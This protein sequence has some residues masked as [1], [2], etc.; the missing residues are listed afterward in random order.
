MKKLVAAAMKEGA[1]GLSTSLQYVPARFAK[2]DE[3]VELAKVAQQYGGIYATHQRSEANALDESLTEVFEISRRGADSRRDLAPENCLSKEL[4]TH[5]RCPAKDWSGAGAG[6][7]HHCGCLSLHRWQHLA[8][9]LLA[10]MGPRR[11]QRKNARSPARS[12]RAAT[13]EK[14]ISTDSKD[15]ENIYLGSGGPSGVLI[16]SVVNRD[17][18]SLQGKRLVEI[19]AGT[20]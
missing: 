6:S 20:K 12:Q 5:A 1:L 14:E 7:R 17:L 19:A 18:E 2:T 15:W 3:I 9:R 4:G 8:Q 11:W 13:A 16:S 10:T